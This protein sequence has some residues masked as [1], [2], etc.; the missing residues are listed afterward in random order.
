MGHLLYSRCVIK[1]FNC[2]LKLA[3]SC[4]ILI[5]FVSDLVTSDG[6]R[7]LLKNNDFKICRLQSLNILCIIFCNWLLGHLPMSEE[8]LFTWIVG[9]FAS[10]SCF[11]EA[12]DFVRR[13]LVILRVPHEMQGAL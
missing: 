10:T 12:L 2:C 4:L 9:E 5:F 8:L 3:R 1:K 11:L 6:N 7:K 13:L